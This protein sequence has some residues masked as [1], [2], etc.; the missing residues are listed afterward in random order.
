MVQAWHAEWSGEGDDSSLTDGKNYGGESWSIRIEDGAFVIA[1]DV[2]ELFPQSSCFYIH[3]TDSFDGTHISSGSLYDDGETYIY[4]DDAQA[5]E[6]TGNL[7]RSPN[8]IF[9]DTIDLAGKEGAR[10]PAGWVGAWLIN[11]SLPNGYIIINSD[12]TMFDPTGPGNVIT[13][14]VHIQAACIMG[15]VYNS[16]IVVELGGMFV[17]GEVSI[18]GDLIVETGGL[19]DISSLK[20]A[21]IPRIITVG[22]TWYDIN[23]SAMAQCIPAYILHRTTIAEV[24]GSYYEPIQT[25]VRSFDSGG[26]MYGV[27]QETSGTLNMNLYELITTG[28]GRVQE[29]LDTDI[30]QVDVSLG[31]TLEIN[32]ADPTVTLG[33]TTITVHTADWEAA[34]NTDPGA[35]NVAEGQEYKIKNVSKTGTFLAESIDP[36]IENVLEGQEYKINNSNKVGTFNESARNIDP[37]VE[38][39]LVGQEYKI[40]NTRK[41]GILD[42]GA[43]DVDYC[44]SHLNPTRCFRPVLHN[45]AYICA[46]TLCQRPDLDT[47]LSCQPN[48]SCDFLQV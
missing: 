5:S 13:V 48:R 43:S 12:I 40:R 41:T 26:T 14:P 1:S 28:D 22:D 4:C 35:E 21:G 37:G 25:Q 33:S 23:G 32:S 27:A 11:S 31:G 19:V 3:D 34:R 45:G 8:I 29:Q 16:D 17:D 20:Y 44:V 18:S 47:S 46:I 38:N 10:W 36:G 2:S 15:G 30:D 39:V 9:G 42:D 7:Y 24:A 6:E